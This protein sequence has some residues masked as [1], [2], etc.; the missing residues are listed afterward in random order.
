MKKKETIKKVKRVDSDI[1]KNS[2]EIIK[3]DDKRIK[4][5]VKFK[6]FNKFKGRLLHIK[7]GRAFHLQSEEEKTNND[8]RMEEISKDIDE[9]FD[10]FGIEDCAVY[11]SQPDVK[12]EVIE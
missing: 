7:V 1:K 6:L 12:I 8:R 9:L 4:G 3:N 2:E 5:D 10:E 11:F